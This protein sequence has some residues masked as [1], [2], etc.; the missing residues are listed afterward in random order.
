M[1]HIAIIADIHGNYIALDKCVEYAISRG[2][3]TFIFLG[4]Y[5]AELPYPQK[6]MERLYDLKEKYN[7]VFIRGNKED[8]WLEHRIDGDSKVV[9]K[10]NDSTTGML[11]YVYNHLTQNDF[12]FFESMQ[13]FHLTQEHWACHCI[14]KAKCNLLLWKVMVVS[15][16][17]NL[18]VWIMMWKRL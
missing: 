13:I 9:W 4:D 5:V 14:V 16:K 6:T 3:D 8:Y 1:K 12:Q 10:D 15:G 7:C 18:S 11:L 17:K 2:V